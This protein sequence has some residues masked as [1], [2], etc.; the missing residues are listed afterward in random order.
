MA[1]REQAGKKEARRRRAPIAGI[2]ADAQRLGV[3]REHLWMV[4]RG[5]RESAS[6][7]RRYEDLK[8]GA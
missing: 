6:L 3:R 1:M 4:L 8:R 7:L 2:C 5:R